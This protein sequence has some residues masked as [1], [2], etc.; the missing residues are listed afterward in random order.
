MV[1]LLLLM[2]LLLVVVVVVVSVRASVARLEAQRIRVDR[3]PTDRRVLTVGKSV[4]GRE[5]VLGRVPVMVVP[6]LLQRRR[7][8]Y[9]P[10]SCGFGAGL[11]RVEV[12]GTRRF[13]SVLR[14]RC[15]RVVVVVVVIVVATAT[16]AAT[17]AQRS[18]TTGS[19]PDADAVASSSS[20]YYYS[21][22]T[23]TIGRRRRVAEVFRKS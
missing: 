5:P 16:V 8:P 17:T 3:G 10:S 20:S 11:G 22:A 18:T 14:S 21:G 6:V 2:M 1:L 23:A 19:N 15:R 12:A 13:V 7:P 9:H 4:T